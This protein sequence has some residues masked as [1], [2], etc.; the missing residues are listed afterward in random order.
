[1][2]KILVL[3]SE[4]IDGQESGNSYA[5]PSDNILMSDNITTVEEAINNKPGEKIPNNSDPEQPGGE[6]FNSYEDIEEY[7]I[8]RN[9]ASGGY[10]H[11]EGGST[12]ASGEASHAEGYHTLA[13]SNYQHVQGKYNI[14]DT[15]GTYAHIVGWGT[16][17]TDRKNIHTITT[18]GD[19]W[20]A[21]IS[22]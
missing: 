20:F 17:N 5:F 2:A 12:T 1:M 15:A 14:E 10:S 7:G 8:S 13:S 11:A 22:W 4:V 6:I 21:G 18:T 16:S 3:P 9:I 19:G